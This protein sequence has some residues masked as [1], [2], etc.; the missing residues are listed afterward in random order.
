MMIKPKSHTISDSEYEE[1]QEFLAF[2]AMKAAC[3]EFGY[4]TLEIDRLSVCPSFYMP[5]PLQKYL[6]APALSGRDYQ[7]VDGLRHDDLTSSACRRVNLLSSAQNGAL[8]LPK[9]TPPASSEQDDM[10]LA[11][12]NESPTSPL[13][14][15]PPCHK[16]VVEWPSLI[17]HPFHDSKDEDNEPGPSPPSPYDLPPAPTTRQIRMDGKQVAREE[18]RCKVADS[19]PATS[20]PSAPNCAKGKQRA[21]P[22]ELTPVYN[23][24]SD[25]DEEEAI[26]M[27]MTKVKAGARQHAVAKSPEPTR[28]PPCCTP[29]QCH[30]QTL[31][32]SPTELP[33]NPD[34]PKKTLPQLSA[35]SSKTQIEGPTSAKRK[36]G[37]GEEEESTPG[38][39]GKISHASSSL[40]RKAEEE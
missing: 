15:S 29:H 10:A 20:Q 40:K 30:D 5:L 28:E 19:R 27:F 2:K 21:S 31:S 22:P 33:T 34:A 12:E 36:D 13:P 39:R 26:R 23:N 35:P 18:A 17:V 7:T 32:Q 24:E 16:K 1:Y 4:F 9:L 3:G 8:N 14:S 6:Y 11:L 25:E 38:R 37:E